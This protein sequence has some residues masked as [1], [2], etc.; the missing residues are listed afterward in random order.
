MSTRTA[1]RRLFPRLIPSL[2][3][4][5]ACVPMAAAQTAGEIVDKHIEAL[6]GADV[7]KAIQNVQRKGDLKFGIMMGGLEGTLEV[8]AMPGKKVYSLTKYSLTKTDMS[9]ERAGY[10]GTQAWSED[11]T[12]GLRKL[13]GAEAQ[14]QK[15]KTFS[16]NPLAMTTLVLGNKRTVERLADEVLDETDHYV[17]KSAGGGLH[18][19]KFFLDKKTNLLTQMVLVQDTQM[20]EITVLVI[21]AGYEDRGGVKLA[22]TEMIDIGDGMFT[23]KIV[24]GEMTVNGKIDEGIF[25]MPKSDTP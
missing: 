9:T 8:V 18:D 22:K 12:Q 6:G 10:N 21:Y 19:A 4:F 16:P 3:V 15:F 13:E 11:A 5:A 1:M 25:D 23:M 20:G 2:L 14:D 24:Y 17:L 7:L